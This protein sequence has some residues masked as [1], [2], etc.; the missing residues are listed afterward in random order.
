M[1][2]L[3]Q[4]IYII[5]KRKEEETKSKEIEINKGAID[6]IPKQNIVKEFEL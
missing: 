2:L 4:I 5:D 3:R 6:L 1:M